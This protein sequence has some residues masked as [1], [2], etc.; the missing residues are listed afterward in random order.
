MRPELELLP[1]EQR[2]VTV[3]SPEDDGENISLV[4]EFLLVPI[5]YVGVVFV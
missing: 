5:S 4:C 1:T 3:I 2:A